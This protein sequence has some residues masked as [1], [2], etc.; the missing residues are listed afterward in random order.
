[1]PKT[2][3]E[4]WMEYGVTTPQRYDSASILMLDFVDFT[5]MTISEDPAALI[6]ELNDIFTAFDRI[7]EQFHCERIKTLGDAYIAVCGIPESIPEHAQ[8]IAEVA[9]RFVRYLE[10]RNASNANQWRCRIGL[11][12]G[13]VIGSIVGV[14]KYV[15]DIFGPGINLAAR[16]ESL[17]EPMTISLCD[18]MAQRLRDGFRLEDR[19]EVA[20]KGFG[21]KRRYT[22][23]P[24]ETPRDHYSI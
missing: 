21:V 12:T 15:Y 14:Q 5:E 6:A 10:R 17:S 4:E 24:R 23:H 19:G 9:L 18:D 1:M 20:L 11:S 16:M 3:Y 22:L 2:I 7:V 8:N 13:P